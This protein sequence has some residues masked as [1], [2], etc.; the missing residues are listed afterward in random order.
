[1]KFVEHFIEISIKL[2]FKEISNRFAH[3]KKRYMAW[4]TTRPIQ[5]C[6]FLRLNDSY[7]IK[8]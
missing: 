1:M 5:A 4:L 6:G 3:I 8:Y 2:N 7:Q